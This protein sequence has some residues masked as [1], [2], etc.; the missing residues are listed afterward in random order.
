M[1][2]LL[3]ICI[4]Q[5]YNK[6]RTNLNTELYEYALHKKIWLQNDFSSKVFIRIVIRTNIKDCEL[7]DIPLR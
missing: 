6:L 1:V 2:I 4:L 5:R 7:S 3:R